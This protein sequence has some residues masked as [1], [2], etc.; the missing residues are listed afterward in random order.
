[1]AIETIVYTILFCL[2]KK[3]NKTL[4]S[5]ANVDITTI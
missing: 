2:N 4:K 1:M 3:K 5:I